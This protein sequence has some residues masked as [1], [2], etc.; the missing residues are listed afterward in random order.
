MR[1]GARLVVTVTRLTVAHARPSAATRLQR[2]G[3]LL[4]LVPALAL[5]LV[6]VATF[7][8]LLVMVVLVLAAALALRPLFVRRLPHLW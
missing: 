4:L 7:F 5:V 3:A 2:M 6:V 8:V 1:G